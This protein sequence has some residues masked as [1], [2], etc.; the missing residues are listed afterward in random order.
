[1]FAWTRDKLGNEFN[2]KILFGNTPSSLSVSQPRSASS[3]LALLLRLVPAFSGVHPGF[4][5]KGF[6]N[7]SSP[8]QGVHPLA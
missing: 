7:D 1:M 8:F 4:V 2:Y 3:C 6:H 5:G